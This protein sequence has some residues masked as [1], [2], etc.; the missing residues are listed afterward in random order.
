[1]PSKLIVLC[2]DLWCDRETRTNIFELARLIGINVGGKE[3]TIIR[4]NLKARYFSGSGLHK[5][6]LNSMFGGSTHA[7]ESPCTDVYSYIVDNF[8]DQ[9]DIWMFGLGIGAYLVCCV[10]GMIH[11]C[12][13]VNRHQN[14]DTTRLS[15]EIFWI[16][17]T[18]NPENASLSPKMDIFRERSSWL[19]EKPIKFIGLLDMIALSEVHFRDVAENIYHAISIHDRLRFI[20]PISVWKDIDSQEPRNWQRVCEKWFPGTHYDIGRQQLTF[21]SQSGTRLLWPFRLLTGTIYPNMVLADLVL[22]WM[23]RNIQD[24]DASKQVILTID[25]EIN[26]TMSR[27]TSR[28]LSTGSGDVYDQILQYAPLGYVLSWTES[29]LHELLQRATRFNG[30]GGNSAPW[31]GDRKILTSKAAVYDYNRPL[32][33]SGETIGTLAKLCHRRYPS[34]TYEDFQLYQLHVGEIDAATYRCVLGR[35]HVAKDAISGEF[36]NRI[37]LDIHW[38]GPGYYNF[39]NE[40]L[41]DILTITKASPDGEL[42]I[43]RTVHDFLHEFYQELGEPFFRWVKDLCTFKARS[44][45]NS[46][47]ATERVRV[48]AI[49]TGPERL[50]PVRSLEMPI[51][52]SL[53][54]V[55]LHLDGSSLTA[56]FDDD[57]LLVHL[58]TN[59]LH[60][61]R[62]ALS[63]VV[64][65]FQTPKHKVGGLFRASCDESEAQIGPPRL[66]PFKLGKSDSD[67]WIK[68]FKYVC[69]AESQRKLDLGIPE[70]QGGLQIDFDMLLPLAGV[71]RA[72]WLTDK[73]VVLFG[74]ETALIQIEPYEARRW[75]FL[76]TP[77]RIV[78]LEDIKLAV[79][80]LDPNIE[81]DIPE[82][83]PRKFTYEPGMAYIG[84]C[85]SPMIKIGT[86]RPSKSLLAAVIRPSPIPVPTNNI[87]ELA[88]ESKGRSVN[89][90]FQVGFS[91]IV[92][93]GAGGDRSRGRTYMVSNLNRFVP[94]E[95]FPPFEVTL[96]QAISTP[97]I[98][99]DN[100]AK[101]SWLLPGITALLFTTLCRIEKLEWTVDGMT[102]AHTS[103]DACRSAKDCLLENQEKRIRTKTGGLLTEPFAE[104]VQQVWSGMNDAEKVCRRH[105]GEGTKHTKE[106]VVFGYD[107]T[108]LLGSRSVKLRYLDSNIAGNNLRSWVQLAQQDDVMVIFCGRIGP[109]IDCHWV[110]PVEADG[111][112]E[113]AVACSCSCSDSC[114]SL[115]NTEG[116]LSSLLEDLRSF[117]DTD[118]GTQTSDS[119]TLRQGITWKAR[120]TRGFHLFEHER[121]QHNQGTACTCC[122]SLERLQSLDSTRKPGM[123]RRVWDLLTG[124]PGE[125]VDIYKPRELNGPWAV[126]F[127]LVRPIKPTHN[128]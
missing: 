72:M 41:E 75:H 6:I 3:D 76:R 21:F 22:K 28:Q 78:R 17:S 116:V 23:L 88:E 42:Y 104:F 44:V 9:Q 1:M 64:A 95:S 122:Q 84:W 66:E 49:T 71:S 25:S 51:T 67:C 112:G 60:L 35:E 10:A 120:I 2:D 54:K 108:D 36:P 14:E 59:S 50:N 26:E 69:I 98:L 90:N 16:Y 8:S 63:W 106:D 19:V 92:A 107:L 68:L 125:G 4:E 127:G 48:D 70:H 62:S 80:S 24:V 34:H 89:L 55:H 73:R 45:K 5:S 115:G 111:N 119:V 103:N 30:A 123:I 87:L 27:L 93:A 113:Q 77:G 101:R 124:Q 109:V 43:A 18:E 100:F 38:Q 83:E 13:I 32:D 118:W 58:P 61:L 12:G 31:N 46:D 114:R 102:Y 117:S 79:P 53:C 91:G 56:Q 128:H 126:R 29:L 74:A 7:M 47:I 37:V 65:T 81:W 40:G 110:E 39:Y 99:W 86:R 82:S 57:S 15:N 11:H 96:E 97:C 52:N 33:Q 121:Q 94:H 20:Q 105:G 85:D